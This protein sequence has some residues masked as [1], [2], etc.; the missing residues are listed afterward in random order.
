MTT[1]HLMVGLPCSGKTVYARTLAQQQDA[2]VLTPDAWHVELF[3]QDALDPGHDRRHDAIER[4]MWGLA[5][6]VL[7]RGT[8]VILDFGFWSRAEQG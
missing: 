6:Q 1:L 8:D 7:A 3:G 2:L 4:I 5:Q